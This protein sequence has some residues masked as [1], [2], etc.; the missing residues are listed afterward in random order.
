MN[1]IYYFLSIVIIS[2]LL[3]ATRINDTNS[4][5]KRKMFA[6]MFAIICILITGLRHVA[7][8]S[9]TYAYFRQFEA[10]KSTSWASLW[11]DF[12][13]Y[14]TGGGGK[15]LGFS[16]LMKVFQIFFG[17]YQFFLFF[18]V[19][20]FYVPTI[21]YLYDH[22]TNLRSLFIACLLLAALFFQFTYTGLRQ[23]IVFGLII[24]SMK[25]IESKQLFKFVLIILVAATLHKTAIV[26]IP[27]YFIGY[28]KDSRWVY[29]GALLLLP[30]LFIY[31]NTIAMFMAVASNEERY[32]M[33]ADGTFETEGTPMF[34]ALIVLIVIAGVIYRKRIMIMFSDSQIITNLI[35]IALMLT[36]L[37]WV[38]PNLMR[39]VMYF[40]LFLPIYFSRIIDAM[41]K[42]LGNA[43]TILAV[44]ALSLLMI[45]QALPYA[46]FWQE[47]ALGDNYL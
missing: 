46:F 3:I 25:Y 37:T 9:D 23:V 24:I 13:V 7:V 1:I 4:A 22:T 26:F 28:V 32:M 17:E 40:T 19:I 29:L 5:K 8:G 42:S 16:V 43:T 27:C 47:M 12:V 20:V 11:H 6:Y 21:K 31:R 14:L 45:K 38:D 2:Y 36:P 39:L 41:P 34:T 33:Y 35:I 30:V 10:M 15:D 44:I 18:V